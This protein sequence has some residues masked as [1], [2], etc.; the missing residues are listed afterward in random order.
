MKPDTSHIKQIK[1]VSNTHWD[2]EFRHSFEKTRRRLLTMMDVTMDILEKDP[3]FHSFTMDGHSI[4]LEDYLEMRP[5]R[6]PLLEKLLKEGRLVAGPWYTLP[7]EFSI[8]AEPLVRNFL[9]GR[10]TVQ[11]LGGT[12]PNIAYTPS[13][14]GQT[15]QLP[16]ILVDFGCDKMMFYRGI[17]H[18]EADAEWMWQS[19]DGTKI[20]ASRFAVYARYNWYYLVHRPT[21]SGR[22]FEKDYVWGEFDEVP[23]RFSDG[24]AGEDLTFDLQK[25]AEL[26]NKKRVK[27]AVESMVEAEGRH[28]TTPVFLA[29]NG[30]DISAAYPLDP[31]VIAEAQKQLG[32]KYSIEH[33]N[34]AGYWAAA[35]KYINQAKIALLTGERRAYLKEGKWTFLFPSTISARTYLKQK[36]FAATVLLTQYAEPLASMTTAFG[37]EYP[38]RYLDRGWHSL[39][40]NHTHDANGGCAPDIVGLDMEYRYRNASDIAEIVLEDAMA[41]VAKNLSPAKQEKDAMQLIIYNSLP[42][43]RDAVAL[44]DLEVPA[45]LKAKF[46]DLVHPSDKKVARQP[47]SSEKSSSFVDSIWEVARILDSTRI[48]FYANFKDLPG[49]GYRVYTIQPDP[50]EP[51]SPETLITGPNSMA[52]EHLAVQVNANGTINI[53]CKKTGKVYQNL[54][55]LSDQGE[56]GNAWK[57]VAPTFDRKYN[58]LGARANVAV[59]IDGPVV[60]AIAVDYLMPVPLDYADGK[61]R[62]TILVDLP[63][64]VE[65][66]LE[67]GARAVKVTMTLDNKARDHWLRVNFPT[68]LKTDITAADSHFDVVERAIPIPDSTGWVEKAGGTH[69]LRTFVSLS[70]N[71]N[72]FALLPKGI[73]EYEAFDDAEHTL[74]LTLIRAC[75][76]KLAVSEEKLTELPDLGVQCPGVQHFE[77]AIAVHPGNWSDVGLLNAAADYAAPVRAAMTGRGQ[78]TLPNELAFLTL[79]NTDLQITAVK[80]AEDGQGLIVR[81]FNATTKPQTATLR[82]GKKLASVVLSKADESP[83]EKLKPTGADLKIQVPIKK[84]ATYRITFA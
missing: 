30:H 56:V 19:P 47:I 10:K 1:M 82:F 80:Q 67:K 57:H 69:P 32:D 53:T 41:Y 43:T 84:I 72:G 20:L 27:A 11:S 34:L 6:R 12:V 60:S 24:L 52:N 48:K 23:F 40:S 76:I 21:S 29:M 35:E 65:Y 39:I 7:E 51:R 38:R 75:R 59:T 77:Y 4:M 74:A 22:V 68:G 37:A 17:S 9:L 33:T 8:S 46:V 16:Q 64:Q 61:S 2:R 78:G 25:P 63:V 36:D 62:N 58:S 14:W 18:H 50:N 81:L 28:F 45:G 73:F 13:S 83:I 44:V 54:N 15:G 70:D 5:E 42:F 71:K 79:D 26:Y 66:R 3:K 31:T 49:L 55:Y